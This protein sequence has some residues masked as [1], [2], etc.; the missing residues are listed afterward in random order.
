MS[1]LEPRLREV[2]RGHADAMEPGPAPVDETLRAGRAGAA[3]RRMAL[4]SVA[5]AAAVAVA[6]GLPVAADRVGSVG[7]PTQPAGSP[8]PELTESPSPSLTQSPTPTPAPSLGKETRCA[9]LPPI[10]SGVEMDTTLAWEWGQ[11]QLGYTDARGRQRSFVLDLRDDPSCRDRPDV[12]RVVNHAL[13]A[14]GHPPW[15]R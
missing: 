2:L 14:G 5:A 1:E 10:P 12:V 9:D 11:L 8:P 15:G 3:R 7:T 4:G 13:E 6:V